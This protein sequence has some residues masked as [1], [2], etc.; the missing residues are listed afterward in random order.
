MKIF[1][2]IETVP[3]YG[4]FDEA[5]LTLQ[6]VFMKKFSKLPPIVKVMLPHL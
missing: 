4:F 5:P 1:I 3:Q 2:D 6:H